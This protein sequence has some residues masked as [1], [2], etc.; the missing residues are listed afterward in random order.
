MSLRTI[1][2]TRADTEAILFDL[3]SKQKASHIDLKVW[4]T[5]SRMESEH[6]TPSISLV[7]SKGWVRGLKSLQEAKELF[8]GNRDYQLL[9]L[10]VAYDNGSVE[11]DFVK[12]SIAQEV[13]DITGSMPLSDSVLKD[14]G[15]LGGRGILSFTQRWR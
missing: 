15:L 6:L 9:Q 1:P 14:A 11:V 13:Y 4:M 10:N 5:S 12:H 3:L 8:V 7:S 2:R